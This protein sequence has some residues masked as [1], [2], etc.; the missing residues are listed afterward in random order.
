MSE[1]ILNEPLAS[2]IRRAAENEG[3]EAEELIASVLRHYRFESQR[4]KITAEAVWWHSV[5]PEIH[6]RYAGEFVAIHDR[7]VVDHDRD[8]DSLRKRIRAR[9]GKAAVLL[10]P[11]EGRREL[12]IVSTR[13]ARS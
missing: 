11:A 9:Y 2:E 8:E 3:V 1:I 7:A 12:R 13:L 4:K 10:T 5:S 6:T